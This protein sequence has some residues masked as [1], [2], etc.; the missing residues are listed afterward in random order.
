MSKAER[1]FALADDSLSICSKAER[2]EIRPEMSVA[3]AFETIV[4]ACIRHFRLNEPLVIE[5]RSIEGLHQA[6]VAIRRLR[7]AFTLFRPV[8]SDAAFDRI[9]TDIGWFTRELGEA[10]NFDVYLQRDLPDDERRIMQSN[11]EEAY[12]A[13]I[14]AMNSQRLQRVMLDLV[15]WA[16]LGQWR[17]SKPA[18]RP[19]R[20]FARRRIDRLWKSV[21]QKDRLARLSAKKRHHLRI[22]AKKLRYSLEFMRALH[23]RRQRR[24]RFGRA[25]ERL[26]D[27][28][29]QANDVAIAR[30][31]TTSPDMW[32]DR[33]HKR[34]V[35]EHVRAGQ[36]ALRRLRKVGRYW[37]G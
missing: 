35:R 34:E 10:R 22:R 37:K 9:E 2:V 21:S 33:R 36:R 30:K 3:E 7:A 4:T 19:I 20:P 29:G 16:K 6:R 12:D 31:L 8:I 1:G 17:S 23:Q 11:R 18:S 25:I 24:K 13:V 5:H 27:E 28:L 26:Q 32:T 15:A 14:A